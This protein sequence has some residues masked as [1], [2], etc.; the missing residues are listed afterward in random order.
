MS[1]LLLMRRSPR[2]CRWD[3]PEER[4]DRKAGIPSNNTLPTGCQRLAH[5]AENDGGAL[6][7]VEDVDTEGAVIRV[8]LE[9]EGA[10][11]LAELDTGTEAIDPAACDV[12]HRA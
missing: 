12:Q 4:G 5:L 10:V 11:D 6:D 9:A 2:S 1:D 8:W 3:D 7:V